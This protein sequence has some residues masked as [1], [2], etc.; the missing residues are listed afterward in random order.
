MLFVFVVVTLPDVELLLDVVLVLDV[1]FVAV[2]VFPDVV[3]PN[4][5]PL[6][7]LLRKYVLLGLLTL[8]AMFFSFVP[9]NSLSFQPDRIKMH[10]Q[11]ETH[12]P[13]HIFRLYIT[14]WSIFLP[15]APFRPD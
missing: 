9:I 2:L 12:P 3:V 10:F 8:T 4:I 7:M 6:S 1:V 11:S 14:S 13:A 5:P 15:D